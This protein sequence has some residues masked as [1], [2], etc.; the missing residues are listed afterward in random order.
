MAEWIEQM[1]PTAYGALELK[2]WEFGRL[3][4]GEFNAMVEGY[5]WRTKEK[6]VFTARFVVPIINAC[7]RNLKRPIKLETF[8]DGKSDAEFEMKKRKAANRRK[9]GKQLKNE[10]SGIMAEIGGGR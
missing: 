7:A 9:S 10:L 3:T 2:P 8:L 6:R 1:T 4:V 5:K